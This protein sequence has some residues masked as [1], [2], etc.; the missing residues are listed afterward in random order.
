MGNSLLHAAA[1]VTPTVAKRSAV[2]RGRNADHPKRG[3]HPS[4]NGGSYAAAAS[5]AMAAALQSADPFVSAMRCRAVI[6]VKRV[7]VTNESAL[8]IHDD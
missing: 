4:Q 7:I 8:K 6:S 5:M 1:T 2:K 3:G